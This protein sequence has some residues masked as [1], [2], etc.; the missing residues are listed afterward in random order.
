MI[1]YRR[2]RCCKRAFCERKTREVAG[3]RAVC[4]HN[5]GAPSAV[6]LTGQSLRTSGPRNTEASIDEGKRKTKGR[7]T[8]LCIPLNNRRPDTAFPFSCPAVFRPPGARVA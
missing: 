6:E 3:F 5:L 4:Y 2:R 7:R 8:R 1:F